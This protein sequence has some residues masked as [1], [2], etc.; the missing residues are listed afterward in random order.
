M[1]LLRVTSPHAHGPMSTP[2]VMQQGSPAGRAL[3]LHLP[4]SVLDP[5]VQFDV[6]EAQ[7]PVSLRALPAGTRPVVQYAHDL[8]PLLL[9]HRIGGGTCLRCESMRDQV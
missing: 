1:A 3:R 4:A 8:L 7:C 5:V 6:A 2:R 9:C